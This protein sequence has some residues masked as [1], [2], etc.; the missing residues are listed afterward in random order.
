MESAFRTF[1]WPVVCSFSPILEKL[2]I[3]ILCR[4]V[5]W[6]VASLTVAANNARVIENDETLAPDLGAVL[7]EEPLDDE[8]TS[9]IT[10]EDTETAKAI[11][12]DLAGRFWW[13][14]ILIII[15][16]ITAV[17]T[18]YKIKKQEKEVE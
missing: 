17:T 8:G 11:V 6:P 14:W 1:S 10:I 2:L 4:V 3:L 15:S 12:E 5:S 7:L 18:T 16:A 9:S 13:Y